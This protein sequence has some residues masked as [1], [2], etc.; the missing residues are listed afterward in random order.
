[1]ICSCIFYPNQAVSDHIS[2]WCQFGPHHTLTHNLLVSV[3]KLLN[4]QNLFLSGLNKKM[5][6]ICSE[7]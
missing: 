2:V 3:V 7:N 4:P 5:D 6:E 1:M